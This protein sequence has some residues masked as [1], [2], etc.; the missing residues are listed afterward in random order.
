M[1]FL[2][3]KTFKCI[4]KTQIEFW[5]LIISNFNYFAVS[6]QVVSHFVE[7]HLTVSI[8]TPVES[9]GVVLSEEPVPQE[10]IKT[11]KIAKAK[12]TF[13]ILYYY[14]YFYIL[15]RSDFVLNSEKN[16]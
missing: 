4:K 12:N 7:S 15:I 11:E 9:V 13:F 6:T 1:L 5:V 2:Y 10:V 16:I 8:A 3:I 14:F